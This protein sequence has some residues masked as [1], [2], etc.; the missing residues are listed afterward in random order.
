VKIKIE[1]GF[2]FWELDYA[3]MSFSENSDFEVNILKPSIAVGSGSIDW[4][5]E[6]SNADGQYMAQEQ[7]GVVTEV[8]Y[9]APSVKDD[10]IQSIFLHSRGY[11]ELVR[12]FTGLPELVELNKFKKNGYFSEFSRKQYLNIIEADENVASV[13]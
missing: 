10:K 7:T 8:T 2:M 12:D 3:A 9:K 6:L 4:T 13:K 5:N 1:T 11:Y